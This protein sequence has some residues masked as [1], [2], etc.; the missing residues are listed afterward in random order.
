MLAIKLGLIIES[1]ALHR[2]PLMSFR[3]WQCSVGTLEPILVI[4][5]IIIIINNN[6]IAIVVWFFVVVYNLCLCVFENFQDQRTSGWGCDL[7]V[8]RIRECPFQ[9]LRK[10]SGN[11]SSWVFRIK[12]PLVGGVI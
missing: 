9:G 12:E 2:W 10:I 11:S 7:K 4:I 8:F 5:I 3:F 6:G 1:L